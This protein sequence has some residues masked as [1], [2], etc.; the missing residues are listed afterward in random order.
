MPLNS[1]VYFCSENHYSVIF[2][3][4]CNYKCSY[5][6]QMYFNKNQRTV[7]QDNTDTLVRLLDDMPPGLINVTGGEPGLADEIGV[8]IDSL[9]QHK[10]TI[11]TNLSVIPKWYYHENVISIGAT[12]HEE[13]SGEDNFFEQCRQLVQN[14]K[15]ISANYLVKPDREYAGIPMWKRFWDNGI[16]MHLIPLLRRYSYP[17]RFLLDVINNYLTSCTGNG[18][19]FHPW[20]AAPQE[21]RKCIAGTRKRFNIFHDGTIGRCSSNFPQLEG[22]STI[23]NPFF[24]DEAMICH[25]TRDCYCDCH[26]A[27]SLANENERLNQFIRTG[28]WVPPDK[29]ELRRFIMT[30]K[31]DPCGNTHD[32]YDNID[33]FSDNALEKINASLERRESKPYN[34]LLDIKYAAKDGFW[35][36]YSYNDIRYYTSVPFSLADDDKPRNYIVKFDWSEKAHNDR[37]QAFYFFLQD[38]DYKN[39]G[40]YFVKN[41]GG[42]ST[43]RMFMKGAAG[44]KAR[45]TIYPYNKDFV[46][47]DKVLLETDADSNKVFL[48]YWMNNLKVFNRTICILRKLRQILRGCFRRELI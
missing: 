28:I 16:P 9:P 42:M 33:L 26:S 11:T 3:T 30:M 38:E 14:G 45:F 5:C 18:N 34:R 47:P 6:F 27:L 12:Y 46:L 35:G 15:R 8:I 2:N 22:K 32:N 4:S 19:F 23:F 40:E 24:Y 25:E 36:E 29:N 17:S 7:L 20:I 10:F 41:D 21:S 13:M 37:K 43:R 39:I 1:Q 31:W 44:L 48:A